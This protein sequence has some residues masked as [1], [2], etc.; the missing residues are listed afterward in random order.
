MNTTLMTILCSMA[1]LG[2]G[3][4]AS[5]SQSK[6]GSHTEA[7]LDGNWRNGVMFLEQLPPGVEITKIEDGGQSVTYY[8]RVSTPEQLQG[9][10]QLSQRKS[11]PGFEHFVIIK[12]GTEFRL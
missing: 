4:A 2:V 5:P 11:R 3:C 9:L 10:Q 6:A 8:F 1:I 12:D 7:R